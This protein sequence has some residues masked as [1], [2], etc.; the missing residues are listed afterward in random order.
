MSFV[1]IQII[2]SIYVLFTSWEMYC[3]KPLRVFVAVYIVRLVLT[4]PLTI[5]THLTPNR[6]S[7]QSLVSND[8][9]SSSRLDLAEAYAMSE[10]NRPV[11]FPPAVMPST[12]HRQQQDYP[13]YIT[14]AH[15]QPTPILNTPEQLDE[16]AIRAWVDR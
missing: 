11:S 1:V 5:Y 15:Q 10:R 14:P 16:N 9:N 12:Q 13:P 8:E 4:T 3:D 7:T 6:R 2:A